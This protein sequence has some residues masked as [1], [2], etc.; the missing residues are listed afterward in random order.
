MQGCPA[1][2]HIM[3]FNRCL[4]RARSSNHLFW[5][6]TNISGGNNV[7][8][9][10][11]G[12]NL[13]G[14]IPWNV[15][16]FCCQ[17][18]TTRFLMLHSRCVGRRL[19]HRYDFKRFAEQNFTNSLAGAQNLVLGQNVS[20]FRLDAF[21]CNY[22]FWNSFKVSQQIKRTFSTKSRKNQELECNKKF[23]L[24]Y[25]SSSYMLKNIPEFNFLCINVVQPR[26]THNSQY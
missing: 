25:R 23:Q 5:F 1:Q 21:A 26:F 7:S 12:S 10:G 24:Q 9:S 6:G 2:I 3:E 18:N 17:Q 15:I 13:K 8:A 16:K 4:L 20:V 22:P 11:S 19:N 14:I